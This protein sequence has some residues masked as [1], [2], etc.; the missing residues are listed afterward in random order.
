MYT[1]VRTSTDQ[2]VSNLHHRASEELPLTPSTTRLYHGH[3]G[4]SAR[5]S[6]TLTLTF[7]DKGIL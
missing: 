7:Q 6:M 1:L 2:H 3:K 4:F 5:A